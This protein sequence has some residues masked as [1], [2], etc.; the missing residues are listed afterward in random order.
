MLLKSQLIAY[1]L[2]G[3]FFFVGM[4]AQDS[5]VE[6]IDR[7]LIAL[8]LSG[9]EAYLGWRLFNDDPANISFNLYRKVVGTETYTKINDQPIVGSTNYIDGAVQLGMAYRYYLSKIR[10]QQEIVCEGEASI[11]MRNLNQPYFSIKLKDASSR[12]KGVGIGDLDGD[13]AYDYVIQSPGSKVDPNPTLWKR[14]EKPF[15][16][17]AYSSKGKHMWDHN[18]GWSIETGVW[19]SPLIVYDLDGD[20]YAEL[21]TKTGEGD[22]REL[23]GHVL[24]GPEYLSKIDGRTGKESLKIPWLS[25][26][27]FNYKYN[28]INRN[29]LTVAYLDGESPSLIMSKGTYSIHKTMALDSSFNQLWYWE[30]TGKHAQ[31]RG[32]G[33]HGIIQGDLDFDGRD[34]LIMGTYVLDHDGKLLWA[35]PP[36]FGHNDFAYLADID[37]SHPGMEIFLGM[38]TWQLERNG[39]CLVDADNGEI[40][41]GYEGKVIH[42]HGQGL[43][44]DIDANYPGME[45]YGLEKKGIQQAFLYSADGTRLSKESF[46]SF[47]PR[48]LWWDADE[49]KEI[50]VNNQLFKYQGDTLREIEGQFVMLADLIGDWREELVMYLPGE[51][52]IY[53]T[54]ILSDTR[55]PCLMQNRQY[56]VQTANSSMGYFYPP[57]LGIHKE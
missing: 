27:G 56:R 4:H 13:G 29:L 39:V 52:R 54:N 42:V 26:E 24:E 36:S 45:C 55:K 15:T 18:L 40:L 14:S 50:F 19:Y 11:F 46:G 7:G 37:P 34:E 20:G 21:Y 10:D 53:S 51:L 47:S 28:D 32:Q 49:Q 44:A 33:M 25:K 57:Q 9:T 23:D 2:L 43:V 17:S 12:I 38:E 8:T 5:Q 3:N 16:L 30:S 48:A 41:W 1:L 31:I 22:P 35:L 6:N